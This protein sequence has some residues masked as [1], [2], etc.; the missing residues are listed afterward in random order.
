M[1]AAYDV[2]VVGAGIGGLTVAALLSARG[3]NVC[4]LERQSQV[5]GCVARVEF[6]G[7]EFEPGMGIYTSFGKGDVFEGIVDQLPVELPRVSPL[8]RPYV[9]RLADGNDVRLIAGDEFFDELR[10]AFPQCVVQAIEFY[11]SPSVGTLA[12]TSD[13]FRSFIET[14]LRGF[15]HCSIDQCSSVAL[16]SALA[17]P[18]GPLY[19][20]HGGPAT[21]AER[22]AESIKRS[23]GTMRLNTPVLRLAYDSM[24]AAAGV[25]L[26]SGEQVFAKQAIISNLT[27]WDTYGKLVGLNRTPPEIKKRLNTL[28]GTGAYVV[29]ATM[30]EAAIARL[31]S[32]RMLVATPLGEDSFTE[33][34]LA[35]RGRTATLQ[36]AT[37]VNDWFTY[38][39][40]EEEFEESDQT[41]LELFW[42][43]LHGAVPE[44]GGEIE[45]VETA[46]P[47][48]YYDLTRRKLG[49]VLGCQ[50]KE[51]PGKETSIPNLFVIGDSVSPLPD[52]AAVSETAVSLANELHKK[53]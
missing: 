2:V 13:Q 49:M 7:H 50:S 4:V 21:L 22:L 51:T 41:A 3:V 11:R 52:L 53:L 28:H 9:V 27:I 19:E 6:A 25:D 35:V 47:R 38:H 17:R 10:A 30:E 20:I 15:L 29:Y 31:P 12:Q 45:V 1:A 32:E 14:Q 8:S 5:G 43:K 44:L 40:S 39:A 34:T 33:I 42:T 26:L 46:N 18:R 16:E 37:D 48:T 36:S 24:G 23:G